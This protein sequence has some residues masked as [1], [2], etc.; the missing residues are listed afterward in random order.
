MLAALCWAL[1]LGG[2]ALLGY[3]YLG[4]PVLLTGLGHLS[5]SSRPSSVEEG[6]PPSVTMLVPVH[7]EAGVI[8]RKVEN[9]RAIEYPG[10]FE[11]LFVSDSTDETDALLRESIG[12]SMDLLALEER[13]GKS[14]AINRG[15]EEVDSEV[16]VFS[17]ANTM[18]EPDAV[19]E[20]VGPLADPDVGC[21]TGRLRLVDAAGETAESAYW[22]YELRLRALESRL[23]S[24]VSVN[25]GLMA[26][27]RAD[28]DP[29]PESALTDDQV[30]A[31]RQL[32]AG[33]SVVYQPDAVATET[34]TGSLAAE[35]DRRV[36]IG[37]GNY[38]T[39]AWF[40]DLLDPRRGFVAVSF[41]SHKVL[42]WVAPWL[43]VLVLAASVA[44]VAVEGGPVP[45][46]VLALQVAC[47]AAALLGLGSA[48]A[49][50]I[51]PIRVPAYFFSMNVA[52]G[53]G[54]LHFLRGPTT[55]IWTETPRE[56]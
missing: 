49:R 3:T 42:R 52:L 8:E 15:L 54:C 39:L 47:Y 10:Q 7:N 56:E 36:R 35:F 53:V 5:A 12:P 17:D 37:A 1:L 25:G 14:H 11:C 29:L 40:A 51:R 43:L 9:T 18:Y 50:Q 38:Q 22:R 41:F 6:D 28:V 30:L 21:V 2:L 55:S 24:T 4:Y 20:L 48:T 26:L 16:V 33:R 27:R 46:A 23:G 31:L 13:R 19:T 44:L 34:T 32:R 45:L